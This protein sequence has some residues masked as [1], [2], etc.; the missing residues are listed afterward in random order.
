[1]TLFEA[2]GTLLIEGN[3]SFENTDAQKHTDGSGFIG[4]EG[5]NGATFVNNIAFGN[6]G[7]CL[8]LTKSSGTRFINNTCY[9]NSQFGSMATGPSNPGELY[10]TNAG[11][12]VQGVTFT[13]NAIVGTGQ[14][15]AGS[16]PVQNMPTTGWSN[17]VVTTGSPTFF[18][19]PTG[20]NPSFVPASGDTMLTG[21][22]ASG[23]G[24]PTADIGLDPKCIVKRTPIMVG[25]VARVS[26]WQYDVDID[27]IKSIGGVAKCFN[28]KARSGTPDIGAYRPGTV[29]TV[30]PASCVAPPVGGT[31]GTGGTV[32]TG[33]AGGRGGAGGTGGRGGTGGGAAGTAGGG[34]GG[35][36]STGASGTG[37]GAAGMGGGSSGAAGTGQAGGGGTAAG[38]GSAGSGGVAGS[39]GGSPGRGGS[40]G[41]AGAPAAGSGGSPGAAG[42]GGSTPGEP[43]GCGCH[44][45]QSLDGSRTLTALAFLAIGAGA[46]RRRRRARPSPE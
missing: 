35:T 27:Y 18:T 14:A 5:S 36:T 17:N 25:Q 39:L 21:K 13:N 23:S 40:P 8:R 34:T 32:G 44:V 43:A 10:F 28:P 4:D 15:P 26:T 31:S 7:S 42:S 41:G 3:V 20:A 9:R 30:T 46:I 2:T 11:V 37:G 38:M 22:G 29:T 33:G 12:T 1:V 45:S 6:S 24:V 16:Q 19:A